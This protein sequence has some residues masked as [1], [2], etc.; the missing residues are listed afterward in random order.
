MTQTP[1]ERA[2]RALTAQY[3]RD[4]ANP[5]L[6]GVLRGYK[7]DSRLFT[8]TERKSA[9]RSAGLMLMA[10]REPSERMVGEGRVVLLEGERKTTEAWQAMIDAALGE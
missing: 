8:K 1:L 7:W 3:V 10:L 4:C 9:L 2:A 5:E 6:D